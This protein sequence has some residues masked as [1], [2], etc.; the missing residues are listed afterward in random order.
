MR[1]EKRQNEN[2]NKRKPHMAFQKYRISKAH[3]WGMGL[4]SERTISPS[5]RVS[6]LSAS[7]PLRGGPRQAS[8]SSVLEKGA[9]PNMRREWLSGLPSPFHFRNLLSERF[10]DVSQFIFLERCNREICSNSK[11]GCQ[12]EISLRH[13]Y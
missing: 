4:E 13:T 9:G 12:W 6:P 7:R 8:L 1:K 5:L 3:E 2:K 10:T 11:R